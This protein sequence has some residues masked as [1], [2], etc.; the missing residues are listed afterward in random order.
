MKIFYCLTISKSVSS[1]IYGLFWGAL[2]RCPLPLNNQTTEEQGGICCQQHL[3]Q[4]VTFP[5]RT[6]TWFFAQRSLPD[7]V[8]KSKQ[9]F[10]SVLQPA[11]S[12]SGQ[13]F[14]W[15]SGS[16]WAP[17]RDFMTSVTSPGEPSSHVYTNRSLIQI[18]II[19]SYRVIMW[20]QSR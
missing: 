2:W 16:Q 13:G 19:S 4:C 14:N 6:P 18:G 1:S 20:C 11:A 3:K 8:C 5:L 15:G 17:V 12:P 7:P 10:G 9:R